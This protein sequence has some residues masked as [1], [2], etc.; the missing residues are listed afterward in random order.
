MIPSAEKEKKVVRFLGTGVKDYGV[1][2]VL[3][4]NS[5]S[6]ETRRKKGVAYW[7]LQED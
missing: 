1:E 5:E 4:S 6:N 7:V 3:F 2:V